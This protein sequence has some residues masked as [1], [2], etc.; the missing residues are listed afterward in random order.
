MWSIMHTY[1]PPLP[2]SLPCLPLAHSRVPLS[3]YHPLYSKLPP[4]SP[5]PQHSQKSPLALNNVT[6]WC[7]LLLSFYPLP[8]SLPYLSSLS[9]HFSLL[10]L[11]PTEFVPLLIALSTHVQ[12]PVPNCPPHFSSPSHGFFFTFHPL[13]LSPSH[14]VV[15]YLSLW[16]RHNGIYESSLSN[17][18]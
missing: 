4:S 5:L 9:F 3:S 14:A 18:S 6:S 7:F 11:L 17:S 10:F 16:R 15:S 1:A 8:L 12:F 2:L 13:L